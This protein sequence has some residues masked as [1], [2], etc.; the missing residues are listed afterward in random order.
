MI[1]EPGPLRTIDSLSAS[2]TQIIGNL[3][4]RKVRTVTIT[5]RATY[6]GSATSAVRVNLYFS[7]DGENYDTI[8]YTY[9]D[10]DVT[11]SVA[12]QETAIIDF[13]E[14]GFM[15]IEIYNQDSS[16]AATNVKV[17]STVV[18]W[19]EGLI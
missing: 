16:Y 7:P 19:P 2:G 10:V 15:N 11:V 13:P 1:R 9:F 17:W 8:P 6:N 18:K 4:C 14:H 5:C 12:C 3:D